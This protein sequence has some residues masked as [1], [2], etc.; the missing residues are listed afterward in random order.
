MAKLLVLC[1]LALVAISALAAPGTYF[2]TEDAADFKALLKAE[3]KQGDDVRA[4]LMA[5][6][7][8]SKLKAPVSDTGKM[9]ESAKKGT[10]PI[11]VLWSAL[12]VE[13]SG[14]FCA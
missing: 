11:S 7:A 10:A 1:V 8:L 14:D 9:C 12:K 2:T 6:D 4:N 13:E 3:M 5:A